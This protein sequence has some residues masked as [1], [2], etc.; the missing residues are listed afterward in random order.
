MDNLT[1]HLPP[2]VTLTKFKRIK[3]L[4]QELI[5][6]DSN[7]LAIK[8]INETIIGIKNQI[9]VGNLRL[10]YKIA[11]KYLS[12]PNPDET[13]SAA[14]FGLVKAVNNFNV[15]YKLKS[16]NKIKFSTF[17]YPVIENSIRYNLAKQNVFNSPGWGYKS[18][19]NAIVD[20]DNFEHHGDLKL[21]EHDHFKCEDYDEIDR[22]LKVC[23]KKE[24]YIII[25]YYG[26]YNTPKRNLRELSSILNVS[27]TTI[28]NVRNR[29]LKKV[30][31]YFNIV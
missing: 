4:E 27:R 9:M 6:Y 10:A 26:L 22:Y 5:K 20:I 12:Y 13:D 17:A 23:D 15:D 18:D 8:S 21:I 7:D 1:K 2:D 28:M 25:N 3:K 30:K 14:I 29:F 31:R 24:K 16:G 19:K 11:K